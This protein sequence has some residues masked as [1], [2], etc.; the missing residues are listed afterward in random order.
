MSITLRRG[1]VAVIIRPFASPS[2]EIRAGLR[3]PWP[4]WIRELYQLE[5]RAERTPP[6]E[7]G[8]V[9]IAAALHALAE[10]HRHRLELSSFV[11]AAMTD[12]GWTAVLEGDDVVLS[13]ITRPEFAIEELE[14]AGV[15]G[16]M[17]KVCELDERGLPRLIESW[18]VR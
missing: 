5:A 3:P 6:P 8:E 7:A 2:A 4:R 10:R 9:S 17:T 15:Y 18:E 16:P 1:A 13:K 12:I 14:A 11:V